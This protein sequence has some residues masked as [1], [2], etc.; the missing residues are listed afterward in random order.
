MSLV[1]QKPEVILREN[2]TS[3]D[4]GGVES[5][6]KANRLCIISKKNLLFRHCFQGYSSREPPHLINSD[7][8]RQCLH[9]VFSCFEIVW[10]R[11]SPACEEPWVGSTFLTVSLESLGIYSQQPCSLNFQIIRMN[12]SLSG[13]LRFACS[14]RLG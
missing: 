11:P 5:V 3:F 9:K 10:H 13:H 6:L 4:S 8:C 12:S 14:R 7:F 2:S 1:L